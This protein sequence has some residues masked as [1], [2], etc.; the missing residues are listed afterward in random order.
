MSW[1]KY[2]KEVLTPYIK[3][4]SFAKEFSQEAIVFSY[5]ALRHIAYHAFEAGVA[6]QPAIEADAETPCEFCGAIGYH[7]PLCMHIPEK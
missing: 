2:N 4:G 1:E 6:S 5:T 7:R 3:T